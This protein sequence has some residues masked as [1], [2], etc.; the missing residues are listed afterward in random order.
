MRKPPARGSAD[1]SVDARRRRYARWAFHAHLWLGVV[2]TT[3]LV[4]IAITG[5][6][7]NHKR[8]LGL[9]PDVA[10]TPAA[11]FAEALP[12]V[13]LAEIGLRAATEDSAEP[14]PLAHVDRMD[15]R[16]RDGYVK[17]RLRDAAVTEV[18]VD[19]TD[20]SV[21]HV[22]PRSDSFLEKVHSGEVFGSPWVLL[23]DAAAV[24][25]VIVLATGYWLWIMPRLRRRPARG[26]HGGDAG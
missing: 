17:V 24:A 2:F 13:Q 8:G 21:L 18:T 9:M 20:G 11:P 4:V 19:L 16:P 7:L 22:G 23:S 6:A 1:S 3:V 26:L 14:A 12:L 25:L 10:H 5:I 15:V